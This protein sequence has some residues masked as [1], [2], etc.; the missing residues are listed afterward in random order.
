MKKQARRKKRAKEKKE[1]DQTKGKGKKVEDADDTMDVD[2]DEIKLV[3]L[4][5]PYLVVR[6]SGKIRSFDFGSDDV[7]SKGGIQVRTTLSR[8]T[9]ATNIFI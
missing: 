2:E 9:R 4:F 1:K 6:A 5:T 7:G 8:F 3:D